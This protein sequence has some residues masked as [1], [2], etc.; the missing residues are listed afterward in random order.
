MNLGIADGVD[1][2]WKLAATLAGWGG[3]ELLDSY[4][5][6]RRAV[7]QRTIAEAVENYRMLSAQL[8]KDNLDEDS[9]AGEEARRAVGKEIERTKTREF[10]TLGVVLGSRYRESPIIVDDGSSPPAEH[11]ANFEPSAFPGCLAP[12]AWLPD[13]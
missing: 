12:H 8:L 3:A 5:Q 9:A 1:L 13:G 4:E 2:G 6:E 7:H 11:H 10:K